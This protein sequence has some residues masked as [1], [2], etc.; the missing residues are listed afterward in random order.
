MSNNKEVK[1]HP[2]TLKM[3]NSPGYRK[4]VKRAVVALKVLHNIKGKLKRKDSS[5]KPDISTAH[6]FSQLTEAGMERRNNK[7]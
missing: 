1:L 6:Y 4:K 3:F 7:Q 5:L 2:E